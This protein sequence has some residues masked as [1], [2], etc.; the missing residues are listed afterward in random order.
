M[1]HHSRAQT[2]VGMNVMDLKVSRF[3][4]SASLP[5][6]TDRVVYNTLTKAI[7]RIPAEIGTSLDMG[8]LQLDSDTLAVLSENGIVIPDALDEDYLLAHW[9]N[10]HKYDRTWL[11]VMWLPTYECNMA[12]K[13]CYEEMSGRAAELAHVPQ[14][15]QKVT[16]DDLV[17][18]LEQQYEI[19]R[20]QNLQLTLF[21][22]E[23]LLHTIECLDMARAFREF[24]E[25]KPVAFKGS[26]ITNGLCLSSATA[27]EL[28]EQG[29]DN[30][31]VTLDGTRD[32]HDERRMARDGQG[33]FDR[34]YR[35]LQDCVRAGIGSILNLRVGFDLHNIHSIH[36]LLDQ[37]DQDGFPQG[38]VHAAPAPIVPTIANQEHCRRFMCSHSD[39]TEHTPKLVD[40]F[41][42]HGFQINEAVLPRRAGL[43]GAI[44]ENNYVVDPYGVLYKCGGLVGLEAAAIGT[45][46]PFRLNGRAVAFLERNLWADC[47]K[48]T[49]APLCG[50]GCRSDALAEQGTAD[51]RVCNRTLYEKCLPAL[52]STVYSVKASQTES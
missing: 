50:G 2:K 15:D 26:M 19:Q 49:F 13:Y 10:K 32:A 39:L 7:L 47:L 5:D 3:N 33:T 28:R 29:V 35:N 43:C 23:P 8:R 31:Q 36:P 6:T 42:Q 25:Q 40:L 20:F 45:L 4:V 30:I 18:W 27:V 46:K 21:G 38:G 34:I 12:C 48:C 44:V 17:E 22:G 1:S 51:A 16:S 37:M 24:A 9:Y 52:L 41:L 11:H 14:S